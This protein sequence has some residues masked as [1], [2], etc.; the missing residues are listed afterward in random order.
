[1]LSNKFGGIAGAAMLGTAAL[2][3]TN[4]AYAI[5]TINT[6]DDPAT[7]A[8]ETVLNTDALD[9]GGTMHYHLM[10][11]HVL[12]APLGVSARD[13]DNWTVEFTFTGMVLSE[14]LAG[15]A[16]QQCPA[17]DRTTT[18]P[19]DFNDVNCVAIT[20]PAPSV[21]SGGTAGASSVEFL[22]N[23]EAVTAAQGIELTAK[24]AISGNSGDV[25]LEI[26]NQDLQ[27]LQLGTWE[28]T[29]SREGI[30]KLAS[31]ISETAMPMNQKATVDS[32][33]KMFESDTTAD[34][35]M[36]V[37]SM[38][39]FMV[40]FKTGHLNA[41]NATAAEAVDGLD[42]LADV[43]ST[44]TGADTVYNS[45]V[46]IMGDFSFASVVQ[47]RDADTA[48]PPNHCGAG[49]LLADNGAPS[50]GNLLIMKDGKV[51]DTTMLVPINVS[52]FAAAKHLC[53]TVDNTDADMPMRIPNADSYIARTSYK[54]NANTVHAPMGKDNKLGMI[55]RDGT[56]VRLPYLST[57]DKFN[58]RI[59]IVNRGPEVKYSMDFH[60]DDD[61]AG[62]D[63]EGMLD[64]NSITVLSLR[65][66]DVVTPGSG[67]ST[68]GSL[69]IEAGS[70][71]I[72]VATVQVN[73]ETGNTDT[74]VYAADN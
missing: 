27:R 17:P 55:T 43:G 42:D 25:A 39:T 7:Y 59:R 8:M 57:N 32:E 6:G 20:G 24:F 52:A 19:Q 11:D 66:D 38:G 41:T 44:G 63:A 4:A 65:T 15:T 29:E 22:I 14:V 61:M 68:S 9:V 45:A 31:A 67:S 74:V 60:G 18:S 3:G 2:L 48:S 34:D 64:A 54:G 50:D 37:A 70:A 10:K 49:T 72:D 47:L 56:T 23:S 62:G 53:I 36:S 28:S 30:V 69:I 71:M 33:F 26:V 40:G 73:R 21:I 58:Q 46:T 51:S 16:L 1:M 13:T 5:I 35:N 12:R